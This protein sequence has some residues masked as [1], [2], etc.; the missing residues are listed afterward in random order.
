MMTVDNRPV[1]GFGRLRT[2]LLPVLLVLVAVLHVAARG[3]SVGGSWPAWLL[4]VVAA[5]VLWQG[6]ARELPIQNVVAVATIL[7]LTGSALLFLAGLPEIHSRVAQ[8]GQ[9]GLP[10]TR[11]AFAGFVW[12]GIVLGSRGVARR[13]LLPQWESAPYR[14]LGT[15]LLALVLGVILMEL[16]APLW[17][18]AGVEGVA[19]YP[20]RLGWVPVVG[21]GF[22]L[23]AVVPFLV[24]KRPKAPVDA[25]AGGTGEPL[26]VWTV[27]TAMAVADGSMAAGRGVCVLAAVLVVGLVWGKAVRA[28]AAVAKPRAGPSMV[29]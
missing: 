24:L 27:L 2:A 1:R 6:L 20:F 16:P 10:M 19:A 5:G 8:T 9:L 22:T 17:Q 23:V 13:L 25:G 4:V 12:N 29:V 11:L 3:S 14:G 28:R 21:L 18:A 7:A 26:V 15:L